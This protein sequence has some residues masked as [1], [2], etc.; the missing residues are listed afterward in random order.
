MC[1]ITTPT[2]RLCMK[3]RRPFVGSHRLELGEERFANAQR[4]LRCRDELQRCYAGCPDALERTLEVAERAGFSLSELRYEYPEELALRGQ[5]PLEYLRQPG[6]EGA[7]Q[8]YPGGV[9]HQVA[10]AARHELEL[11]AELHYE[12]Y[13]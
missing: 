12:A 1:T 7:R 13:F 8:R 9:P 5:S 4:H 11:I 3:S 6:C 2:G 10:A